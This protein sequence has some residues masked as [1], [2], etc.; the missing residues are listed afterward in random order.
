MTPE[1]SPT[2]IKKV[3][4]EVGI[5]RGETAELLVEKTLQELTDSFEWIK[6]FRKST[7]EEDKKRGV[8]FVISTKDVGNLFLQIKS[9]WSGKEKALKK[10]PRIPVV[11]VHLGE[12]LTQIENK[13]RETLVSQREAFLY[14]R[15][16]SL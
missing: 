3:F 5:Q 16:N 1:V 4:R 8:D 13:I 14:K 10:H 7:P 6:D 12:D 9:S 15:N 11:V 2:S